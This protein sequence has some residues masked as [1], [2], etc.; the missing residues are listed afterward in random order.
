MYNV[1]C[2]MRNAQSTMMCDAKTRQS[3]SGA[4]DERMDGYMDNWMDGW[5]GG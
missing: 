5:M 4:G 2:A 1:Q 3:A